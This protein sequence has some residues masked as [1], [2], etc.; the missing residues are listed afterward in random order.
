[1]AVD[2]SKGKVSLS[3]DTAE[4]GVGVKLDSKESG[5]LKAELRW[6]SGVGANRSDLDLF[7]WVVGNGTKGRKGGLR[8]MLSG[9]FGKSGEVAEVIYHKNL[10]SLTKF[11]YVEHSGDSKVPGVET[12]RFGALDAIDYAM[13]GAYQFF[14]NGV[15]S[16]KS[17]DAHVVITDTEGNETRVNLTESHTSRYWV[18]VALVDLTNPKGYIVKP[19]EQY[20]K[21]GTEKSPVLYADGSFTMNEGPTYLRK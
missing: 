16:L 13:V 15:G 3:K 10:G 6:R 8:G 7:G 21:P 9:K 4:D 20:S 14:G 12:I 19:V 5:I 18:V 2:F 17:F 1:M 11:P